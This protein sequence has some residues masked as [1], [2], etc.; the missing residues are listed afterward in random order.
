MHPLHS[1][2][3][4]ASYGL[5]IAKNQLSRLVLS[6]LLSFLSSS[7]ARR[8][9]AP[10]PTQAPVIQRAAGAAEPAPAADPALTGAAAAKDAEAEADVDASAAKRQRTDSASADAA[11]VTDG[12]AA[13]GAVATVDGSVDAGGAADED[14]AANLEASLQSCTAH[15]DRILQM[16]LEEPNNTNLIELRDQLTNAINQL[17][18]S[19][20]CP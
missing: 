9:P 3:N 18:V 11:V 1:S 19:A 5:P 4:L 16:L 17:Q 13:D 7:C 14:S 12:D 15:R 6:C 10:A 20:F 8:P 2:A